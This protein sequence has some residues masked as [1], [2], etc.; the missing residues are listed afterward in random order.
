M[1]MDA[2][3]AIVQI[4]IMVLWFIKNPQPILI[5]K[6]KSSTKVLN[7]RDYHGAIS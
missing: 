4:L 7:G 3:E 1:T 2:S 5:S 6:L